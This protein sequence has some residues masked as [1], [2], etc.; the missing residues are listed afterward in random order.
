MVTYGRTAPLAA[1]VAGQLAE[2]GLSVEVIDL[3][4]LWPWDK[5]MVFESVKK[6]G[7][8][9]SLNEDVEVT[10]FG[11][12]VLR[13]VTNECFYWLE[14]PPRLLAGENTPGIGLAQTLE[15]VQVPQ[16]S[17]IEAAMRALI[18]TTA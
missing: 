3:R 15:M 16:A 14:A 2:E 11:E 1:K 8:L 7:R 5:E 13:E 6:T 18:A 4:S 9:L 12:H 17:S 10:N